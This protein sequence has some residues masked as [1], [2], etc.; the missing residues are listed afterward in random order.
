M[1]ILQIVLPIFGIIGA[2]FLFRKYGPVKDDWVHVL[3]GF[4]YYVSLPA[5]IIIG[6]RQISWGDSQI[7]PLFWFNILALLGFSLALAAMLYALRLDKKIKAAVFMTALAGNTI[8][9]GFP[10]LNS[11]SGSAGS[12][13]AAGTAQLAVGIAFCI[14][15]VEFYVLRSRQFK[16]YF[17][18]FIRHPLIISM[19]AGFALSFVNLGGLDQV[20]NKIFSMLGATASPVALFALGGFI[21][22]KFIR[23]H[24]GL[25]G[26]SAVLKLMIF[27]IFVALLA[28]IFRVASYQASIATIFAGMPTAVTAFVVAEKYQLDKGFVANCIIISTIASLVTISA[29]LAA[30]SLIF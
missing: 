17:L 15:A 28:Y 23:R 30:R 7:L 19:A 6:F 11:A 9:M 3:N 18:D 14:L 16:T 12:V 10:I 22:G 24:L 27:P 29:L 2:G 20:I 13:V 1:Q 26:M 21:H 5:I 25:V 4:V 8:Y